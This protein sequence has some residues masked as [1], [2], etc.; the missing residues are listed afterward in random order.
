MISSWESYPWCR[1]GTLEPFRLNQLQGI[2]RITIT[3]ATCT[4]QVVVLTLLWEVVTEPG[5]GIRTRGQWAGLGTCRIH[6]LV[7][8]RKHEQT[9]EKRR[10][11]SISCANTLKHAQTCSNHA[12]TVALAFVRKHRQ[13]CANT[14]KQTQ[15]MRKPCKSFVLVFLRNHAQTVV[16]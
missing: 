5:C 4:I 12:K 16:K 2:R 13:S 6:V 7:F 10:K 9:C 1:Q 3:S 8:M 14:R 11:P 15:K